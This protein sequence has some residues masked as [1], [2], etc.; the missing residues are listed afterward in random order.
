ML[1]PRVKMVP[2]KQF[3]KCADWEAVPGRKLTAGPAEAP[4]LSQLNVRLAAA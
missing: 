1:Y 2:Y 4:L 3:W